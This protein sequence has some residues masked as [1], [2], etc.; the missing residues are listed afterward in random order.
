MP[1]SSAT[2]GPILSVTLARQ[3]LIARSSIAP[4]AMVE[5]RAG[6]KAQAPIPPYIGLRSRLQ[7]FQP[8]ELSA[9]ILDRSVVRIVLMRG[10]VHLVTVHD[11]CMPVASAGTTEHGSL[12]GM[13]S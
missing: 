11:A 12:P 6:M 9:L 3:S 4:M 10:T 5:H 7:S 1:R 8:D 13:D 2:G